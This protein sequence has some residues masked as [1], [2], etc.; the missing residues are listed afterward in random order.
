MNRTALCL[1]SV[2]AE[3]GAHKTA[4]LVFE[5]LHEL[6]LPASQ[7][8]RVGVATSQT[9]NGIGGHGSGGV[10]CSEQAF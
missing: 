8:V 7:R 4:R 2:A 10:G 3:V 9:D 1:A 5:K 6:F